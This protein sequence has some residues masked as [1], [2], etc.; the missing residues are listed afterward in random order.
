MVVTFTH[1]IFYSASFYLSSEMAGSTLLPK[2]NERS[3]VLDTLARNS[4]H[5]RE[6]D[7]RPMKWK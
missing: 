6:V 7:C 3:K 5:S 2:G 1:S 4:G